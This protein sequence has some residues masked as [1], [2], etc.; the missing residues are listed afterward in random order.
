MGWKYQHNH[1]QQKQMNIFPERNGIKENDNIY[2]G[3]DYLKKFCKSLREHA[4][5]IINFENNK[6]RPLTNEQT[7]LHKKTK[8]FHIYEKK[9]KRK[10]TKDENYLKVKDHRLY[11]GKCRGAAH[12][13]YNKQ[14]SCGF[15]QWM[16]L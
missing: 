10:N 6:M 2:R 14:K 3:E 13:I 15:L 7:E 4:L 9:F 16:E 11:A 1:P 8:N 5:V 12:T